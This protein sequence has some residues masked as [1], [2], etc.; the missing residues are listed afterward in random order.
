[1]CTK[2]RGFMIFWLRWQKFV[3]NGLDHSVNGGDEIAFT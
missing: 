3:G 1:M 2:M